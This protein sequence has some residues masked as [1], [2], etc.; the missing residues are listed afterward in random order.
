M[1]K[2]LS[3]LAL[4]LVLPLIAGCGGSNL[5]VD[6]VN[7]K[8]TL[9]EHEAHVVLS[10]A[11]NN[12]KKFSK[13]TEKTFAY[14]NDDGLETTNEYSGS[15][16][17]YKE[18]AIYASGTFKEKWSDPSGLNY[19]K[20]SSGFSVETIMTE[21]DIRYPVYY[22]ETKEDTYFYID[23]KLAAD[24]KPTLYEDE[25]ENHVEDLADAL[26][27]FDDYFFVYKNGK[28]YKAVQSYYS[29]IVSPVS[30]AND[31]V[32]RHTV[33]FQRA[34]WEINEKCQVTSHKS[35]FVKQDNLDPATGEFL[36]EVKEIKRNEDEFKFEYKDRA[37]KD[38]KVTEI[39]EKIKGNRFVNA[40]LE[41][42]LVDENKVEVD[43]A[44]II[45]YGVKMLALN[46][47][48]IDFAYGCGGMTDYRGIALEA[49][50][51]FTDKLDPSAEKT[52]V[53]KL[54]PF[55]GEG[56]TVDGDYGMY[57]ETHDEFNVVFSAVAEIVNNDVV[58]TPT[59]ALQLL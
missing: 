29:E 58:I 50:C 31:T 27:G 12:L 18:N 30:Y 41:I 7:L 5:N 34:T 23:D 9:S 45:S 6:K 26:V 22:S 13:I 19:E 38:K 42:R 40:K 39:E 52:K 54:I 59:T 49:S 1:H 11:M 21:N 47:V 15:T 35:L 43:N 36:E 55:A 2:K 32:I 46:K 44:S 17:A 56:I 24:A 48:Q 8:D 14:E 25:V 3:F 10:Q 16:V 28:G 51:Y 37:S 53:E 20:S 33:T 4:P 57:Q